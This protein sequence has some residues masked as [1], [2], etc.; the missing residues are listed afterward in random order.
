MSATFEQIPVQ[1]IGVQIVDLSD[2]ARIRFWAHEKPFFFF[3][4]QCG[5]LY[6]HTV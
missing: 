6:A 3:E 1:D 4:R 2:H 5:R